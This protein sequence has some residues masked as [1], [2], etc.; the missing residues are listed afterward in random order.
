MVKRIIN[1]FHK[2]VSGL[3][4]AAYLLAFFAFCSQL[5][6]LIRDRIF[7]SQFG[8]GSTLDLYYTAFRIPDFIF[9]T[10][11]SMVSISVLIP[12][13]IE[14]FEKGEDDAKKFI[15]NIFSFFFSFIILVS[16]VAY[17]LT[18]YLLGI[19][20][21]HF[22]YSESFP[23]LI[24]LTRILLLS[25]IFLGFS[26]LLA[27]ITQ[28]YKRFV[29]YALSPVVYNIGIILGSVVLYPIF[30][31]IGLGF[32]VVI[33]AFLH[34]AIQIPFL[35]QRKMFPSFS[36]KINFSLIKKVV[37]TS[38]PRTI[39]V[40]S[41]EL[42]K[43]FLISYATFFAA[44]SV[45]VFNLSFNL[46]NVPFSIIGMSYSLAAFPTLAKLFS[47]GKKDE[48]FEQVVSSSKHIIFWSIPISVLFIVLR[49]QIVRTILGSGMFNWDD[50]R[51]TAAALA[52]FT[53]SLV[54]QNMTNLF[55]RAFYSRGKTRTPLVMN[56]I[57]AVFIVTSSF[58]LVHLF[59]NNFVFKEFF[60]SLLKVSDVPGT[61]V[62]ML[63]LGFTLG[64][65]VN[66]ILHW[67]DFAIDFKKYTSNVIK[68]IFHVS[69]ASIIMGNV[70]YLGL[71]L[72][73]N[74]LDVNT[75]LGIFLQGLLAGLLGIISFVIVLYLLKNEELMDVW[76]TLHAKIWKTKDVIT[77]DVE[78]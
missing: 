65:F 18:P 10:V 5:L 12:F 63:P 58:F 44:G 7:A 59:Q 46:Q 42:A 33:G 55:V 31:L 9:V 14:R 41:N 26:N 20:F 24:S 36:F 22:L 57:S 43:L 16:L 61:V 2:E 68:T 74:Y 54:A 62:L 30:G 73:D 52:I 48:F 69:S 64:L 15:D 11:A 49:A 13:L 39:T 78:L 28:V 4:Q 75:L 19:L 21:P 47:G 32:G 23:N 25:P 35:V 17:F 56:M 50:T 38:I 67:I 77:P 71:N 40:S 29:I 27:S 76:N 70:S 60:E 66:L 53:L 6:A 3:H 51:L 72:L 1:L 37:Y 34:F 45:S 8:A